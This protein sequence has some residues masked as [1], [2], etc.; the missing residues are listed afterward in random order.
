MIRAILITSMICYFISWFLPALRFGYGGTGLYLPGWGCLIYG[1]LFGWFY[2]HFEAYANLLILPAFFFLLWGKTQLVSRLGS[3][4]GIV[5]LILALQTF[6]LT[7][8]LIWAE[9]GEQKLT[10][11]GLGFYLWLFSFLLVFIIALLQLSPKLD[12]D[13]SKLTDAESNPSV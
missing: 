12:G 8:L 10:G 11:R 3:I 7:K 4:L 6:T 9:D 2:L 13:N 5:G 1:I